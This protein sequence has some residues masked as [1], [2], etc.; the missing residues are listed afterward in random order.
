MR[1]G[2][3]SRLRA[4]TLPERRFGPTV[5]GLVSLAWREPRVVREPTAWKLLAG[6]VVGGRVV[7]RLKGRA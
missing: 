2:L 4:E 3:V 6:S 7:E 1:Q 5:R